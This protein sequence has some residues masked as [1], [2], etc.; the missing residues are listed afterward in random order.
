MN[1]LQD[2][3]NARRDAHQLRLHHEEGEEEENMHHEDTR[4]REPSTSMGFGNMR[5][6]VRAHGDLHNHN[7]IHETRE[8]FHQHQRQ[9]PHPQGRE[10]DRE[11]D[12][13]QE[14]EN[15]QSQHEPRLMLREL[16]RS[17]EAQIRE[18]ERI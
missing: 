16:R 15:V 1:H 11:E 13:Q 4:L 18:K 7:L 10:E 2:K 17:I 5:D 6:S 12:Q 14:E 3:L 9:Q 8:H